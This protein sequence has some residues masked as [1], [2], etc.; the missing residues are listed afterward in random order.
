LEEAYPAA[1]KVE[2]GVVAD[3]PDFTGIMM[4]L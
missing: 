1:F 4:F 3:Q 2:V